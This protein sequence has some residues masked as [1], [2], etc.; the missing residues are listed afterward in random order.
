[1]DYLKRLRIQKELQSLSIGRDKHNPDRYVFL[2]GGRV[3]KRSNDWND[4]R[5]CMD[6]EIKRIRGMKD[7]ARQT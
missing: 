5:K 4:M 6:A 3:L 7:D 2:K 1:M